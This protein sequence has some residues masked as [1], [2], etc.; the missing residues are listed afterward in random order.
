MRIVSSLQLLLTEDVDQLNR[1]LDSTRI[2][3]DTAPSKL[4]QGRVTL[5]PSATNIAF[6]FAPEV[7]NAKWIIVLV[8]SGEVHVKFNGTGNAPLP[9]K[10]LAA[11]SASVV[12]SYQKEAQPGHIVI[13]PLSTNSP[14]TSIHLSNP[15]ASVPAV[16]YL[17]VVG[18]AS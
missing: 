18:E 3:D 2:L 15:S 14:I 13:G 1:Y 10:P 4:A 6:P 9:V 8:F 5:A 17:A 11:F 16:A 7:T 12:S